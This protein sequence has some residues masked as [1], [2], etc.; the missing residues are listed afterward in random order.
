VAA[1]I[2]V[3]AD[4]DIGEIR[5]YSVSRG[6]D[7]PSSGVRNESGHTLQDL[8]IAPHLRV[9]I[10]NKKIKILRHPADKGTGDAGPLALDLWR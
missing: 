7:D 2:R 3:C 5:H 10:L 9:D 8:R 4:T 1:G 6:H